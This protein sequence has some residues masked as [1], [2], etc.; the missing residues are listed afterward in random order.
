MKKV[1]FILFLAVGLVSF[2]AIIN[3]D[4]TLTGTVKGLENGKTVVLEKQDEILGMVAVDS[5]KVENE[6]FTFKGKTLEPSIHFIQVQD[7]QG[8]V[9]FILENGKINFTIYKDSVA[10]SRIGGTQNNED[11][12]NFNSAAM[13]VQKKM[14]DFQAA[15][16]KKMQDAQASND[17][18]TM[19]ALMDE[20]GKMQSEIMEMTSVFPEKNPKSFLSI[21]FLDNM[22]NQQ[23][24]DIEKIKKVYNNLDASLKATKP[25]KTVK[26][27]IDNFKSITVGSL[28][29]EF[30]APNPD[31]KVISLKESLGKITI[32]DFWASWCGPCR[33]ENPSV[34]AL[35]NEY[36]AKGLNIIGV[37][38][39]KD[40]TKWKEAIAKDN[41]TWN[42]I[43]NLKFWSDP[44]AELYNVKSIPA[45]FIL[46]ANGKIIARDLR[47]AELRAK[48]AEIL[49]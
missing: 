41:L 12:Q 22:F 15:N 44:I 28:A 46:D 23:D 17:E 1:F 37:S 36:H 35:Y 19:N 42:H 11:L 33:Q 29:P 45:T 5:V 9:A 21:L 38:L 7:I 20:F 26:N 49:K 31:G 48:V 32:I 2:Q 43:S 47:G 10:K 30:S 24:V 18:A 40:A 34:V 8:K 14:Q 39:D 6:K 25:G 4:Y 3:K 16:M 13:K 27:K